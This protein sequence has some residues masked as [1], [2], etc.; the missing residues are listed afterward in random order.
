MGAYLS[1]VNDTAD[2]FQCN[3]GDD[4]AAVVISG[5]IISVVSVLATAVTLGGA[6]PSLVLSVSATGAATL[7]I[8][9]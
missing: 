1:I 7:S 8:A 9:S 3:V 5:I 6:A 4:Q 2:T